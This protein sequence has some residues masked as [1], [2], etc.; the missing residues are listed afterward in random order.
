MANRYLIVGPAWV[1]DMVMAQSLFMTLKSMDSAAHIDVLAPAW[2]R[3]LLDRMPEVASAI[4]SPFG[5]GELKLAARR[6]LGRSL[7]RQ[8]YDHA[9]VLPNSIKAAL[10]PF[11]ARIPTRTGFVGEQR[12]G[13][14]NDLRKLDKQA[15]P[16][17]VQR[18]VSLAGEADE[19]PPQHPPIPRLQPPADAF[20]SACARF[21]LGGS[22][23][24][25]L[26]LAPG[27][28]FGASKRWP[29]SH[30]AE[31][32]KR[33]LEAG[34]QVWLFGSEKDADVT[35]TINR[36]IDGRGRDLAGDTRL[37]DAIDLLSGCDAVVTNDSGLMHVAAAL[38][39]PVAAVYGSTSPTMT[40]P[41]STLA[42]SVSIEL[43]CRPCF[44][45]ECPLEHMDCLNK[46]HPDLVIT[47]LDAIAPAAQQLP[48][49]DQA[50][51]QLEED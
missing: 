37:E 13:L 21:G 14:L 9:I 5:H 11:F 26:A 2:T 49:A 10:V 28:E 47:A 31:V 45:R 29:E 3:P 16:L 17:T 39:L 35:A 50:T 25:V 12:Y 38:G 18:F 1:G 30:F 46:L 43:E 44:K 42:Q 34:W 23:A 19:E 33:R 27:A 6:R 48:Q 41:L 7:I 40:P 8:G 24:P 4:A 36:M 15:L 32:A 20:A 51:N 22:D